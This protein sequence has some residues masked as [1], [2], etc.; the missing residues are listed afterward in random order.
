MF[1][2]QRFNVLKTATVAAVIYM[3]VVAIFVVPFVLLVAFARVAAPAGVPDASAIGAF[4]FGLFAIL[5][6]GLLGW[7][8]TPS[9]APSTTVWPPGSAGSRSRWR[10]S[11]HRPR[12]L[13]GSPKDR[14]PGPPP[15]RPPD[16]GAVCPI[17]TRGVMGEGSRS[18]RVSAV[19][20]NARS[21]G[22]RPVASAK[23]ARTVPNT[24][25]A[26]IWQDRRRA[27]SV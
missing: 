13:P 4:G 17:P 14:R 5:I 10:P 24:P 2:I 26:S 3:V 25:A 15:H 27:P 12:H 21:S 6:Y 22:G 18:F 8:G 9:P 20:S 11:R 23:A 19:R 16:L 7:I 1:R